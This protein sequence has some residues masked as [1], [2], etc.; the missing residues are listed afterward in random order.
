MERQFQK[1][2][3][4]VVNRED[5]KMEIVSSKHIA[6]DSCKSLQTFPGRHVLVQSGT[7]S[8]DCN[9]GLFVRSRSSLELFFGVKK[10]WNFD[11]ED[12][13]TKTGSNKKRNERK[14]ATKSPTW[15]VLILQSKT[16]KNERTRDVRMNSL[17]KN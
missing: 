4:L 1:N 14:M 9:S 8:R 16:Q 10:M 11:F 7:W 17:K 3:F 6:N 5:G 12:N 15:V 13:I 2:H